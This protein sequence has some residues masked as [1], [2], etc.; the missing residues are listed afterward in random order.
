MYS[1]SVIFKMLQVFQNDSFCLTSRMRA[2]ELGIWSGEPEVLIFDM[3]HHFSR[4][5]PTENP[6]GVQSHEPNP[7]CA[8]NTS[9]NQALGYEEVPSTA[10]SPGLAPCRGRKLI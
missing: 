1:L 10:P 3:I 6:L 8:S 9:G 5:T 4:P 7:S 2:R